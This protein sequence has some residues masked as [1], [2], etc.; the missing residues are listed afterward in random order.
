MMAVKRGCD[1]LGASVL[2]VLSAP[3]LLLAAAAVRLTSPG[4][5]FFRQVR[6]GKA[7]RPFEMFKLRTMV[8]NAQAAEE[9]LARSQSG[10]TFL[11]VANDPRVTRLGCWLRKSSVDELPQL[12]NVLRGEMSLVGPRPLLECDRARFPRDGRRRRFGMTPGLTG[13]WQVSGRSRTTFDEMVR[14]D[15]QYARDQ[16]LWLDLQILLRTPGAMLSGS[17]AY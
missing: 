12:L 15:L 7:G 1:V 13:L 17:G 11:K 10:R 2:L 8:A 9:G 14:L 3:L 5:A 16:S 4:P 6:I